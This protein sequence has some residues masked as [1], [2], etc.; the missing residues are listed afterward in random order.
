MK[1]LVLFIVVFTSF[2]LAAFA[3]VH[4]LPIK[5]KVVFKN[6][7]VVIHQLDDHTW[8]GTGHLLYN[9][10]LYIVEGND[11][12]VLIDT[13]MKIAHLDKIVASITKKP[14]MVVAT[15]VHRDHVGNVGYFPEVY[16]NPGDTVNIPHAMPNYK[17]KVKYLKDGQIIDLGGRQLQVVFTPAHTPGSTTYIDK[18]AGYGF[19]GDSFGSGNLL[20]FSGTF[21]QLIATCDKMSAIMEKDDIKFLYPGHYNGKNPETQKRVNDL[22]TLS[23]DVLSGKMKGKKDPEN[24]FGLPFIV[25]DY[26][27]RI[28]YSEKSLK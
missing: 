3:Q 1:K 28:N 20:L 21:S 7:D 19:S 14:I 6:D 27:V 10:S 13:G 24:R 9:E 11:K 22:I 17:G 23:R 26:G 5:G 12:A 4:T 2:Q 18:A 25:S 8:V 16:I 15:H